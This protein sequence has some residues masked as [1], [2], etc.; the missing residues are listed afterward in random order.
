MLS[1]KGA[2]PKEDIYK[3]RPLADDIAARGVQT[4]PV[5]DYWGTA[6]DGNRRLAACRYI[7]ASDE[8]TPEQKARA[9]RVRVWQTDRHATGGP[10]PGDC[11]LAQLR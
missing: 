5:I 9:S 3:I 10:D 7:L 6:W 8:Y 2:L 11:H 1:P 4:P